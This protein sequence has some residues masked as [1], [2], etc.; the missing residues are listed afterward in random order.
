MDSNCTRLSHD[1]SSLKKRTPG[2]GA[3]TGGSKN[4]K[5]APKKTIKPNQTFF[6]AVMGETMPT[7]FLDEQDTGLVSARTN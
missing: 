1:Q 6:L 3:N 7:L 4:I 5:C 2:G